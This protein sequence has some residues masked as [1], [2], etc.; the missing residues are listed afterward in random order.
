VAVAPDGELYVCDGYGNARVHRFKADGTL[1]QSWGE[2]G[3]GPGQ[4][5][6]PHGVGI[7]PMAVFS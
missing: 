1:I 7:A 4:F 5:N 6:L 2:P 3:I